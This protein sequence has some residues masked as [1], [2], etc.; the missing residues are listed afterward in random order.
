MIRRI[1]HLLVVAF[2]ACSAQAQTHRLVSLNAETGLE[3]YHYFYDNSNRLDSAT[4]YFVSDVEYFTSDKYVYNAQGQLIGIKGYQ[5]LNG[6]EAYTHV[7]QI[8]Y[9][10]DEAGNL[11]KRVNYNLDPFGNE[12]FM[13]GGV[14]EY[15]YDDQNRVITRN[16]YWDLE[17]TDLFEIVD[18]T[19]NAQG[20][21]ESE[22]YYSIGFS[23]E[24]EPSSS[25]EYVYEGDR[26]LEKKFKMVDFMS[27]ELIDFGGEAYTYDADGDV[28]K[29]VKYSD[30]PEDPSQK[31]MYTYFK[32][33]KGEDVVLPDNPEETNEVAHYSQHALKE[34]TVYSTDAVSGNLGLYDVYYYEYELIGG[35]SI[36][37]VLERALQAFVNASDCLI[38]S[39]VE[40]GS[41]LR[42]Y[43]LNGQL[44]QQVAY[45]SAKGVSVAMLPK[46]VYCVTTLAG[47]VKFRKR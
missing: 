45:E 16:T 18:F 36:A 9:S 4:S 32:D 37:P 14:Y 15:I 28:V 8:D 6:E 39:G 19:Y 20:K 13:L 24:K 30:D 21:K 29:W 22:T 43:N 3:E 17:Q 40:E 5:R 2:M 7:T 23:G 11:V 26:L 31:E 10:Y 1:T 41:V 34:D 42:I 38:V 35:S 47:S 25:I 44:L 12:G 33:M 46:G 27:G